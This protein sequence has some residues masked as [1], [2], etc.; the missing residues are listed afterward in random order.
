M[1]SVCIATYNGEKYIKNQLESILLQLNENDEIIISDDNSNDNT[2]NTINALK[3]NRIKVYFNSKEQGYTKNFESAL[4][5]ASGDI[6]FL[7]DQD[8]IWFEN[9]VKK[10]LEFLKNSDFVISDASIVN[11]N[12]EIKH[13][14]NFK[15]RNVNHSLLSNLYKCRYLGACYAFKRK[16]LL[17]A[18]PFPEKQK[19]IP[20]DYWLFMVGKVFFNL[21]IINLPLIKYRRHDMNTSNGGEKSDNSIFSKIK[22]RLYLFLNLLKRYL[23]C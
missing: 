20:H 13:R 9:K 4:E 10:S 11:N 22:I 21:K 7:S 15:L 14:S 1:I 23:R 8:D 12:L 5:R 16:V 6:I 18:L 19:L 3:D 17:K 2:I